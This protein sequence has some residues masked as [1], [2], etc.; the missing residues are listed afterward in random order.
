MVSPFL[1][2]V[3]VALIRN[4]ARDDFG[5]LALWLETTLSIFPPLP[6]HPFRRPRDRKFAI[7]DMGVYT[8][9]GERD[10]GVTRS[11]IARCFTELHLPCP[12]VQPEP[13]IM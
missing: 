2:R 12:R 1:D 6:P 13:V 8:T 10:M 3:S 9:A 4:L 11:D 7:D 5:H